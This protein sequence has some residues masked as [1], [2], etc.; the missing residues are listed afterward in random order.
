[1]ASRPSSAYEP[2]KHEQVPEPYDPER[3]LVPD[4]ASKAVR[5]TPAR[6]R[7]SSRRATTNYTRIALRAL[8]FAFAISIVGVQAHA[9]YVYLDTRTDTA[10]N[11]VTNLNTELWAFLDVW[12][13]WAI[14]G[15]AILATLIQIVA[16]GTLCSCVSTNLPFVLQV[17]LQSIAMI[18]DLVCFSWIL[19][20]I[21]IRQSVVHTWGAY[22]SSILLILAW[23]A[24]VIYF[25][26]VGSAG[27]DKK[28]WDIWS[29]SC[30][31]KETT[32]VHIPWKALCVENVR[33]MAVGSFPFFPCPEMLQ[34]DTMSLTLERLSCLPDLYLLRFGRCIAGRDCQ[35][36]HFCGQTIQRPQGREIRVGL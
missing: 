33:L 28:N 27:K 26:L 36:C 12:P 31:P 14:L 29:W 3:P 23:L 34:R 30:H 9:L 17:Y 10:V 11:R 8:A 32:D 25:K 35:L 5:Q 20:C 13:N 2:Y 6:E 21:S 19:Q 7:R 1:M 22:L 15:T 24:A 16:L 18:A 4:G